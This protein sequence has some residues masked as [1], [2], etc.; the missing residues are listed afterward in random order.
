MLSVF[1][2][3]KIIFGVIIS[4]FLIFMAFRFSSSYME[5]GEASKKISSLANMKIIAEDVYSS[6]IP[7][8]ITIESNLIKFYSPPSFISDAGTIDINLPIIF[9]KGDKIL[10]YR[11]EIDYKWWNYRFLFIIPE[12]HI[13]FVPTENTKD[14]WTVMENLTLMFP[15]TE[16]LY[17]KVY[18]GAGCKSTTFYRPRFEV[19]KFLR[20]IGLFRVDYENMF[21]NDC[22]GV[23]TYDYLIAKILPRETNEFSIDENSIAV[24]PV[25]GNVGYVYINKS[26]KIKSHVYKNMIDIVALLVSGEEVYNYISK[27]YMKSLSLAASIKA[28][29]ANML[30]SKGLMGMCG[31]KYGEF[32]N[33]LT[34]IA[35]LSKRDYES[36]NDMIMLDEALEKSKMIYNELKVMGCE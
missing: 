22:T 1:N 20:A 33:T 24:L 6:G 21:D 25:S 2:L 16:R 32:A 30:A 10:I 13:G 15:S 3:F 35:D 31:T 26:G 14:V 17:P 18:F 9:R 11:Q 5:I 36:L 4:I 28:R 34:T 8:N 12:T 29:E 19:K 27:H 23:N 7:S